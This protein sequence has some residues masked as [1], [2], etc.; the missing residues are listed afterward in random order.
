MPEKPHTS[1]MEPGIKTATGDAIALLNSDDWYSRWRWKAPQPP[2]NNRLTQAL[3]RR[4][5]LPRPSGQGGL[6]LI[7]QVPLP[8]S[9]SDAAPHPGLFV[10]KSTY[11][12]LVASYD[13][14][15]R[16][17]ADYDFVWRLAKNKVIRIH[18][19]TASQYGAG[20]ITNANRKPARTK[21]ETS[22]PNTSLQ[23][24]PYIAWIARTILNR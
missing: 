23:S 19:R 8:S 14:S 2:F 20:R 7:S 11:D 16:I 21:L 24:I 18:Q 13:T 3:F 4:R 5:E 1:R 6:D 15:Y 9:H 17:S 22:Q 10:K 12:R